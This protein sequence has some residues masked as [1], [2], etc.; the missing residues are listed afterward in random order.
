MKKYL[1]YLPALLFVFLCVLAL[2]ACQGSQGASQTD[3]ASYPG[4][5]A[6]PDT[7][8]NPDIPASPDTSRNPDTP[9]SP[10]ASH[11][12][13]SPSQTGTSASPVVPS[14]LTT[15][16]TSGALHVDGTR[17][18]DEN[19]QVVQL[20]GISTHGLAWYPD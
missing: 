17:L 3:E 20:K 16:S 14:G 18:A 12:F 4:A 2:S 9:A 1:V 19:G 8:R 10:D 11:S 5:S 15:P 7:S 6:S 13:G